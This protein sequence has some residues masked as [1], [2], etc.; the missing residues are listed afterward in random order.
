LENRTLLTAGTLIMKEAMRKTD[1]VRMNVSVPVPNQDNSAT[2]DIIVA[3]VCIRSD[4][5]L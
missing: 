5:L 1:R 4:A 2:K 3:A